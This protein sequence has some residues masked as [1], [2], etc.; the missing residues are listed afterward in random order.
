MIRVLH[1]IGAMGSGGAETVLM[2]IYRNID[3]TKIQFDF[4]VHTDS[5]AFYDKEILSLGGRIYH[6]ERFVVKN[7]KKYKKFWDDFFNAHREYHIVHG[8]INSSAVIYLESAKRYGCITIV[9][10]HNT[11]N[12]E[13]SVKALAFKFFSYPLRYISDYFLACSEQAAVDRFGK[14]VAYSDRCNIL[15]NGIDINAFSF[16][17]EKRIEIRKELSIENDFVIGHVGRF[18]R[19]KNH[20]YLIDVFQAVK[21]VVPNTK[22]CLI[23]TGEL[24]KEIQT[25][26]HGK[27]L[28]ND[29]IFL[30]VTD[31]VNEYLMA[32]DVF[33]FPSIY[34][35]LGMSLVE[36]QISGLPCVISKAIQDEA[37]I[38]KDT[39]TKMRLDIS[40]HEWA[41]KI[42][43]SRGMERID[44]SQVVK[45]AGYDIVDVSRWLEDYYIQLEHITSI[46]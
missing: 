15:R 7:Y 18:T 16:S 29:V 25:K 21:S 22:L 9:H 24:E 20:S 41:S 40:P 28:D 44:N 46:K 1:V 5:E 3:R 13:L 42:V 11:K 37:V 6:T 8:H 34:E 4:A 32:M 31:R 27:K 39:V 23:G 26:V 19:Q 10:S 2:N 35:G 12:P 45:N 30:G 38:C 43:Q 36:A 17:M 14:H 33:V